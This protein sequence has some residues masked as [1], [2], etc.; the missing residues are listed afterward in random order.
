MKNL[1]KTA[2]GGKSKFDNSKYASTVYA[3]LA[4]TLDKMELATDTAKPGAVEAFREN[5][6]AFMPQVDLAVTILR[7]SKRA[8]GAIRMKTPD[9]AKRIAN[10]TRKRLD[11]FFAGC[12]KTDA[13][14]VKTIV[15]ENVFFLPFTPDK[16]S[17]EAMADIEAAKTARSYNWLVL[18]VDPEKVRR[19]REAWQPVWDAGFAKRARLARVKDY[20]ALRA[21]RAKGKGKPA[22]K[23]GVDYDFEPP[24]EQNELKK[25]KSEHGFEYL[26]IPPHDFWKDQAAEKI[27][28]GM[29]PQL[30]EDVAFE[31]A[32]RNGFDRDA[33]VMTMLTFLSSLIAT[34]I[35]VCNS[36]DPD[37]TFRES[38][39]IWLALVGVA[40]SG[41]TP[42]LEAVEPACQSYRPEADDH[43]KRR[44]CCL[45]QTE[46]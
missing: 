13:A 29:L 5:A 4:A 6:A 32:A 15:S 44:P 25:V 9:C 35:K 22:S 19:S 1:P 39:R 46:P 2:S 18:T 28:S 37:D 36:D 8:D 30:I 26:A 43:I 27:E 38:I 11:R 10:A 23:Q 21:E 12:R 7:R 20:L 40:G 34:D 41:K 3:D 45:W 42:I 14:L 31:T 24:P 17:P 16:R 33:L